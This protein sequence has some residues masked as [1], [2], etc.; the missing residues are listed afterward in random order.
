MLFSIKNKCLEIKKLYNGSEKQFQCNLLHLKNNFGIL[1]FKL[2]KNYTVDNILL[3]K[4][5]ISIGYF[6]K[7]RPYNIYQWFDDRKLIASYFNISDKTSLSNEIFYWRDL[8]VDI[9]V[10]PDNSVKVLDKDEL[11]KINNKS[12]LNYISNT[13]QFILQDYKKIIAK[14]NVI[15]KHCQLN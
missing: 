4:D 1:Q 3:P 8:I 11:F 6:W 5:T 15:A 14:I 2:D 13:E 9:I 10:T 12:I 7:N